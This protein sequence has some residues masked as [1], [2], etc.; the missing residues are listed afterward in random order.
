M[1]KM[2]QGWSSLV[3]SIK[4]CLSSFHIVQKP[5]LN[6]ILTSKVIIRTS[7]FR[8][9]GKRGKDPMDLLKI[10][11]HKES[12]SEVGE[13]RRG[14]EVLDK[15]LSF[16][17][18]SDSSDKRADPPVD[19]SPEVEQP[20]HVQAAAGGHG[21]VALKAGELVRVLDDRHPGIEDLLHVLAARQKRLNYLGNLITMSLD[22]EL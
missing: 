9:Q 21:E 12:Q 1:E 13:E 18:S 7:T 3:A 8:E 5:S 2:G 17:P 22:L 16:G 11:N 15:T 10:A 4:L 6:S 14:S 19:V 20:G